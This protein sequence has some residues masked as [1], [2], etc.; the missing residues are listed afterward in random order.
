MFFKC[1]HAV[2]KLV[3][4]KEATTE[5]IDADFI[6]ITYHLRCTCGKDVS[7]KHAILLNGI[8]GFLAKRGWGMTGYE[9]LLRD[10]PFPQGATHYGIDAW[11][12]QTGAH[13]EYKASWGGP[14]W[15]RSSGPT[16]NKISPLPLE[17]I[18]D[19]FLAAE[20]KQV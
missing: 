12:R 5:A 4:R 3:V 10:Q 9:E 19:V 15:N 13:W 16:G 20:S 2:S 17:F 1:R 8:K 11:Y 18:M 14:G 6:R 7:I